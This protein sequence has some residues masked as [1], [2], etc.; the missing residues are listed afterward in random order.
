MVAS[1][2]K[3]T[4]IPEM[5]VN[6]FASSINGTLS[7]EFDYSS[8]SQVTVVVPVNMDGK[9]VAEIIADPVQ[10]QIDKN[11]MRANRMRGIR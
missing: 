3:L 5:A 11:Q 1:L 2:E 10:R 4:A 7:S 6:D 9:K 8:H